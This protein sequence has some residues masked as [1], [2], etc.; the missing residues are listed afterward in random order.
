MN[1][2][3]QRLER[4]KRRHRRLK[5]FFN[6]M[7]VVFA[8]LGWAAFRTSDRNNLLQVGF[9]GIMLYGGMIRL[10]SM[11]DLIEVLEDVMSDRLGGVREPSVPVEKMQHS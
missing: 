9:L 7:V 6:T 11:K 8:C 2:L 5:W 10:V 4:L 3:E 1:H